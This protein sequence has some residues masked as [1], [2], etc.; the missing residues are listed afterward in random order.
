MAKARGLPLVM[1]EKDLKLV[2]SRV[3]RMG[4]QFANGIQVTGTQDSFDEPVP[5]KRH[6]VGVDAVAVSPDRTQIALLDGTGPGPVTVRSGPLRGPTYRMVL[7]AR[8]LT[9]PSYGSGD[10]GLW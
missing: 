8:G 5:V 2:R 3:E 7:T 6:K 4:L 9:S 10:R 1:F